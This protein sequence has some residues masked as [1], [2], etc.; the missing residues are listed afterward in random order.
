[1]IEGFKE[2]IELGNQPVQRLFRNSGIPPVSAI[3]LLLSFEVFEHLGLE[4]RSAPHLHDFK[5][6]DQGEMVVQS[7]IAPD[8]FTQAGKQLLQSQIGANAFIKWVFV[9]YHAAFSN[10][11]IIARSRRQAEPLGHLDHQN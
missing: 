3:N 10:A 6:S 8:K 4:F 9:Q 11:A 5:E 1:M 7:L 2:V